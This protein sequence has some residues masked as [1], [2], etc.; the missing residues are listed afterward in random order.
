MKIDKVEYPEEVKEFTFSLTDEIKFRIEDPEFDLS[1]IAIESKEEFFLFTIFTWVTNTNEILSGL[2]IVI[3]EIDNFPSNYHSHRYGSIVSRFELLV[4]MFF[5][6]F[7]RL[8]EINAIILSALVRQE[9]IDKT[10]SNQVKQTFHDAFEQVIKIRNKMV[11][12]KIEW[13]SKDH[14]ILAMYDLMTDAG[15]EMKYL[16]SG[17]SLDIGSVLEKRVNEFLPLMIAST[18]AARD[19]VQTFASTTCAVHKQF[20]ELQK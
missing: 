8:R 5:H 16:D 19:F 12:D 6:E 20:F 9:V 14:Q 7:Y 15:F 17:K 4:R 1:G 3:Y 11:H 13:E 18:D 10:I 2:N